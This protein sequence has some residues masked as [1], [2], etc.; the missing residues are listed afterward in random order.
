MWKSM[1]CPMICAMFR[2]VYSVRYVPQDAGGNF[3]GKHP[4]DV[5]VKVRCRPQYPTE[6][7]GKVRHDIDTGTLHFD[8]F[9]TPP[10]MPRVPDIPYR[11][12]PSNNTSEC[13]CIIFYGAKTLGTPFS[14]LP[15]PKKSA[16][17]HSTVS[18]KK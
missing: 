8:K 13:E 4:A 18:E 16:T 7:S 14:R 3:I 17:D 12:Y 5:I 9:G 1:I 15:R 6:H 2:R 11:K 10:K